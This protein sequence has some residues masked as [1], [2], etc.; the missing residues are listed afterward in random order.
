VTNPR[1]EAEEHYYNPT[2]TKLLELGLQPTLLSETL[3]ESMLDLNRFERLVS[4]G[5]ELLERGRP[6]D[7]GVLLRESLALWRGPA[8]ADVA[9]E[10]VLRQAAARL[11]ELRLVA[12]ERR[13]EADLACGRHTELV[14]E[15]E[16]LA[17]EFPLRERPRVLQMLA[18][19]RCGRQADAL[20][21]YRTAR[22][23]L[24]DELGIEPGSE[25]QE[26]ER[27]ILQHDPALDLESSRQR[28]SMSG[29]RV[30]SSRRWSS[31][32]PRLSSVSPSR[33]P[34]SPAGERS[35]SRRQSPMRVN[36][37]RR[38]LTCGCFGRN[39]R[40]AT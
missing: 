36:S 27:A 13:I 32:L 34:G 6:E 5:T 18:L 10:G 17:A 33:S 39:S 11:D 30:V 8:L 7:A 29:A 12:L 3:I 14:G 2:H 40:F 23:K 16:E 20:A 9:D 38:Q 15:L 1:L 28:E 21:A 35:S 26:L 37:R 25:M 4:D 24:V 31:K 19:Y 22:G